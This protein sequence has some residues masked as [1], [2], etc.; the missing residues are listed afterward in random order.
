[1]DQDAMKMR[2][3]KPIVLT[4]MNC[5]EGLEEILA[6]VGYQGMLG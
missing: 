5:S 2:G 3:E 1:M 6:I 4:D